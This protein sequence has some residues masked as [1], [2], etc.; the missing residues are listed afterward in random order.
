MPERLCTS[1]H[2]QSVATWQSRRAA[3]PPQQSSNVCFHKLQ[4][5]PQ[6]VSAR[7]TCARPH[8]L[9]R[10]GAPDGARRPQQRDPVPPQCA[11]IAPWRCRAE[12]SKRI[13]SLNS[14]LSRGHTSEH[15]EKIRKKGS[16]SPVSDSGLSLGGTLWQKAN[17]TLCQP[18]LQSSQQA[19]STLQ[20]TLTARGGPAPGVRGVEACEGSVDAGEGKSAA[21][22]LGLIACL[23]LPRLAAAAVLACSRRTCLRAAR[24]TAAPAEC[25]GAVGPWILPAAASAL[26]C[27]IEHTTQVRTRPSLGRLLMELGPPPGKHQRQ[28]RIRIGR[29]CEHGR[30]NM[31]TLGYPRLA[32]RRRMGGART[33]RK[34]P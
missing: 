7:Q 25:I 4:V 32:A 26:A 9:R 8:S 23:R 11:K 21:A 27:A 28:W 20:H 22:G 14:V 3:A 1:P 13:Q 15:P 16:A 29:T 12:R 6:C 33:G 10:A 24:A 30:Q 18:P 17:A 31:K 2:T 19:A 34:G 5:W